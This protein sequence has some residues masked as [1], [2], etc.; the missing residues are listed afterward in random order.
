MS[1]GL[2][3]VGL[4]G[5]F[6]IVSA[7]LMLPLEIVRTLRG[8]SSRARWVAVVRQFAIAVAML[9]AMEMF[10]VAIR[11]ALS[12]VSRLHVQL[13]GALTG[14]DGTQPVT[15]TMQTMPLL[16]VLLTG[17]LVACVLAVAKSAELVSRTLRA[18]ASV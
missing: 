6:F 15:H 2:P 14:G 4:S 9:T 8:R 13:H 17:G 1:A 16:P 3:G 18:R 10:Y 11:F 5:L 7:L 12:G